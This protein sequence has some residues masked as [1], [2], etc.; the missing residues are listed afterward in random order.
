MEPK[1]EAILKQSGWK[2]GRKTEIKDIENMYDYNGY[3]YN[4]L[5]I[6]FVMEYAYLKIKYQHPI[7]KQ[8]IELL[9]NPIVAQKAI[10]MDNVK[11]YEE[12]FNQK[13][14]IVGE[15]EKENMTIFID[16]LGELYGAYDDCVIKWG[17]DFHKMLN[18]LVNGVKGKLFIIE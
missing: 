2:E 12:F 8:E 15:I 13:F 9:M 14:L 7:W 18:S 16:E 1:A 3:T 17:N 5:Q 6:N 4:L 10:D 11:E